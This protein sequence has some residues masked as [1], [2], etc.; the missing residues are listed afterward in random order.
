MRTEQSA[1][2]LRSQAARFDDAEQARRLLALA[3]VLDGASRDDAVRMIGMDCQTLR[4]WVGGDLSR[5]RGGLLNIARDLR[6]GG[7]L[8]LNG[9]GNGGGNRADVLDGLSDGTDRANGL[10][11][12]QRWRL[13]HAQHLA[14]TGES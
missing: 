9:R 4:D 8:L 12:W 5:I 14:T 10:A 2:G 7:P 11:G 13:R 1:S 6:R 3:M